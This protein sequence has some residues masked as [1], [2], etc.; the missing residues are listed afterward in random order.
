M[1][2]TI[3]IKAMPLNPLRKRHTTNSGN[4]PFEKVISNDFGHRFIS[5]NLS[6]K[7]ICWSKIIFAGVADIE[8]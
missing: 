1:E 8:D 2:L 4:R 5:K 3:Y 6:S 7:Q